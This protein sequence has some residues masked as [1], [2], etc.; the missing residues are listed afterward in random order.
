MLG[1]VVVLRGCSR[2]LRWRRFGL[3]GTGCSPPL[4][5]GFVLRFVAVFA[6]GLVVFVELLAEFV[7]LVADGV[8]YLRGC[9]V[10]GFGC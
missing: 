9:C 8:G 2:W 3:P 5:V 1:L 7:D 6:A 4:V 10:V